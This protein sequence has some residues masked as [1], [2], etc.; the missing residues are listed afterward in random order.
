MSRKILLGRNLVWVLTAFLPAALRM[1]A[2]EKMVPPPKDQAG[3]EKI[4][5][6]TKDLR[7]L[8]PGAK[9]E[10]LELGEAVVYSD[11]GMA[12]SWLTAAG[13]LANAPVEQVFAA[14]TDYSPYPEFVPG[15]ESASSKKLST[16][17]LRVDFKLLVEMF[18]IQ[19]RREHGCY[20][21]WRPPYR[22]DR[23]HAEGE[24]GRN[25]GFAELFGYLPRDALEKMPTLEYAGLASQS[26]VV[27]N[28]L[29]PRIRKK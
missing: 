11:H 13:V 25:C 6:A 2:Q 29:K 1:A 20:H 15:T 19:Y 24:F 26:L 9:P 27:I 21:W 3:I 22:I 28:A 18:F 16:D 8:P 4:M 17:F 12:L 23:A 7:I 10:L 14:L 5:S